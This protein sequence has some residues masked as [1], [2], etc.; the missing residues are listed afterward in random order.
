MTDKTKH[1][2]GP[3]RE[4]ESSIHTDFSKDMSY[5]DYL[6]LEGLLA[7]QRPVSE[8]HDEM[9]FIILHQASE[10]WIKL[11]IFEV[12]AAMDDLKSDQ[13]KPAFQETLQSL[14]YS[15]TNDSILG[16]ALHID[17]C[18]L[19]DLPVPTGTFLRISESPIP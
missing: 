7:A 5:A 15:S 3:L 6:G 12:R 11:M 9:L 17:A 8:A 10:L 2:E 1:E 16:C 18:G 4:V 14:P 19:S 13:L